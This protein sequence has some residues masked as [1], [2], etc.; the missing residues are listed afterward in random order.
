VIRAAR[1]L[2]AC[3]L[4]LCAVDAH[5]IVTCSITSPGFTAGYNPSA[6][7]NNITQTFF[8]VTC[9]RD[10][11]AD[12]VTVNYA[13]TVNNGANPQG[14]NNRAALGG[15]FLRYDV[16]RDAACGTKWK[17]TTTISGSV[18]MPTLNQQYS[19]S[20]TFWGCIGPLQAPPAGTYTD[21][22]V[23]ALVYNTPVQTATGS[24][25]VTIVTPSACSIT[26]SPGTITM[27][28]TS[29]G[30]VANG[31][32]TYGVTCTTALPYSMALD[33]TAGTILGLNYTLSL[34]TA[35]SS[36]TGAEQI[37]NINGSIAA[38]QSGSC[39]TAA[40]SGS[41]L[42]SVTVTY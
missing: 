38:G 10:S 21:T 9:S 35:A 39:P 42:R 22:V 5:A 7:G 24:F 28:Y 17:G 25:A 34:G 23:M 14:Q 19:T 32:T 37:F 33:A 18:T 6:P 15:N 12:P 27:N 41:Q 20:S 40:C 31:A 2:A 1:W 29:F 13:T 26:T 4:S 8:T 36:G 11:A 3:V 30:A 16:F